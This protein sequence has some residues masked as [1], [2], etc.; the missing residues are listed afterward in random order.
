MV[1]K[2]KIAAA[3]AL[4]LAGIVAFYYWSE[5]AMI[6]RVLAVMGGAIAA[7]LVF[8]TSTPGKQFFSFAEESLDEAK[9]VSWPTRKETLQT[10][11]VVFAFVLVMAMFLWLIDTGLLAAVGLLLGRSDL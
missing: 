2:L 8:W 5:I 7:A 4:V 11:G 3:I 10:T 6:W 1:D 9:R